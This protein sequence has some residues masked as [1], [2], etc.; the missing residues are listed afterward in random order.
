[1]KALGSFPHQLNPFPY[2]VVLIF[3]E[4]TLVSFMYNPFTHIDG[5]RLQN[6]ECLNLEVKYKSCHTKELPRG[7]V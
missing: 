2:N 3:D 6:F 4:L 5:Q 1:M 7:F